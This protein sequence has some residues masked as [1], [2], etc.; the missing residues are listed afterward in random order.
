[1]PSQNGRDLLLKI[2]DG[3]APESFAALGA[4]RTTSMSINNRPADA[5]TM[6]AG[7]IQKLIA[8]AGVQDMQVRLDGLFKDAAAEEL[9][10]AA[11]FNRTAN[12]YELCFPNGGKYAACFVIS[13][14]ARGGSYDGL[15]S[16][17][18]TLLRSGA[19]T[20]TGGA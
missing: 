16:F 1:M 3:G 4:A 8:A 14:Y 12:N 5:T 18:V 19:G 20:Y 17:S 15:E 10:R 2:G 9:L 7:G 6:D 13:E 11:A